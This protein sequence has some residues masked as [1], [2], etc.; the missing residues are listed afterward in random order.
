MEQTTNNDSTLREGAAE[1]SRLK[2]VAEQLERQ[3]VLFT[4]QSR[5]A[6]R[7]LMEMAKSRR[8]KATPPSH[9]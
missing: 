4:P 5:E 2:L 1:D 8:V 6:L 3:T 7:T 9:R